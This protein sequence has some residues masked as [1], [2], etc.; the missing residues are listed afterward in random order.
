M[1]ATTISGSLFMLITIFLVKGIV[2][3]IQCRWNEMLENKAK[4]LNI[5]DED[6]DEEERSRPS[7]PPSTS[8]SKRLS[9]RRKSNH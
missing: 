6:D 5:N 4:Q 7:I 1:I 3:K 9:M 8:A 2:E